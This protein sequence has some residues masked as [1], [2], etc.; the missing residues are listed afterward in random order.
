M[1]EYFQFL[2]SSAVESRTVN[3][4]VAGSIPAPGA[5]LGPLAQLVRAANS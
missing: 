5:N 1:A 4:F 3:A 2:G